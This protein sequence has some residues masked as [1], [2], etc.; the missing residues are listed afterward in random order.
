M[1][2][3][4]FIGIVI[5]SAAVIF[6]CGSKYGKAIEQEAV[7]KVLADYRRISAEAT[8]VVEVLLTH[9]GTEYRNAYTYVVDKID[10]VE[11]DLRKAL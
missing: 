10:Q 5:A 1:E 7:A 3:A 8:M 9:L 4:L 6:Y 11:I 2:L